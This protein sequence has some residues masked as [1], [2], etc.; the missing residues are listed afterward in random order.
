MDRTLL[1]YLP[2]LLREVTEF[3]AINRANE[4]EIALA[5]EALEQVLGDQFLDTAGAQGVARW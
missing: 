5:W 4:P 1:G 2:P 3:R